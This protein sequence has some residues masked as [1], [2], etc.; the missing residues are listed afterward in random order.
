[1][2]LH[3]HLLVASFKDF[4]SQIS[5]EE[6]VC[7]LHDTDVDGITSGVLAKKAL[8]N[9]ENIRQ[10]KLEYAEAYSFPFVVNDE[11]WGKWTTRHGEFDIKLESGNILRAERE[12]SIPESTAGLLG[13]TL[14]SYLGSGTMPQSK[15]SA[16]KKKIFFEGRII[17]NRIFEYKIK[18]EEESLKRSIL[19]ITPE[20]SGIGIINEVGKVI[21]V[22]ETDK[23]KKT[24]FYEFVKK[25]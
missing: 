20:I 1:M 24:S 16:R 3:N 8:E 15:E 17:R 9:I 4:L 5:P 13:L 14:Q 19:D 18:N 23:D 22:M 7:V 12:E 6:R 11:M 21:K 10:F 2:I 25:S